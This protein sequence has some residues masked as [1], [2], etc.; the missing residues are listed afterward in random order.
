MLGRKLGLRPE[1][2]K[3]L[4]PVGAAAAIAAAFNTPLAAVLF[5]LEEVVGDLLP[6][7]LSSLVLSSAPPSGT[8]AATVVTVAI[9]QII[10][11]ALPAWRRGNMAGAR[12]AIAAL[13]RDEFADV[14]RTAA[15]EIRLPDE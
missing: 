10:Q 4:L 1:K 2:V 13:L 9:I 8:R 3:A 15:N 14:A 6:P 11:L 12:A 7:V 5:A